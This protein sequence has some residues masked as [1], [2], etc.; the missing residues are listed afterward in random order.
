MEEE[1]WRGVGR[2]GGEMAERDWVE[3]GLHGICIAPT[4][5]DLTL[6]WFSGIEHR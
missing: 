4:C 1:A 6:H 5:W 2:W 3:I